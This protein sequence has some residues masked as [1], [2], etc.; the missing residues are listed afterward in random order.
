MKKLLLVLLSFVL[1]LSLAG[2][3]SDKNPDTPVT[4]KPSEEFV[5]M[6]SDYGL[7]DVTFSFNTKK[8]FITAAAVTD[9]IL[10]VIGWGYDN[11]IVT[12]MYD[13][14]YINLEGYSEEYVAMLDEAEREA[15]SFLDEKTY[16][17]QSDFVIDSEKNLYV[18]TLHYPSI[19]ENVVADMVAS[20]LIQVDKDG[21]RI[22]AKE[23]MK[24]ATEAENM[25]VR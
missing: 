3:T 23:T 19:D 9:S 7:D 25:T 18:I 14:I 10:E 2:C 12:E 6:L 24:N 20:G 13:V 8:S 4:D 21:N 15:F 16:L 11:D 17:D 5:S 22:S 1:A